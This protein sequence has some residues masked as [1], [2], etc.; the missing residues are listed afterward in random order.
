MLGE[1]RPFTAL[2]CPIKESSLDE[3]RVFTFRR[4]GF[5]PYLS[6]IS[7]INSVINAR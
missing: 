6:R 5:Q 1:F 3:R 2:S 4:L 7:C